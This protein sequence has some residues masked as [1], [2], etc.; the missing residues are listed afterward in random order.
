[1]RIVWAIAAKDVGEGIRNKTILGNIVAM[2]FLVLF[3]RFAPVLEGDDLPRL[4]VYDQGHSRL[5]IEMENSDQFKF[6]ELSSLDRVEL[7]VGEASEVRLGLVLP[8]GFDQALADGQPPVL[9]GYVAHWASRSEAAEIQAFF[10]GQ[11]AELSGQAVRINM[12]NVVYHQV[13][14]GGFSF[15]T[16]LGGVVALVLM[17]T[18]VTH[19][20]LEEK[21]AKTI[22]AL[23]VSPASAGQIVMG[24]AVAGLVYCLTASSM[25]FVFNAVVVVNWGLLVLATIC[26]ALFTVALGLLMGSLF[27]TRQQMTMWGFVLI[28]VLLLPVFMV[29]MGDIL[30]DVVAVNLRWFPTVALSRVMQMSFSD[31]APLGQVVTNLATVL[32]GAVL[33]LMGVDIGTFYRGLL[34]DDAG[35]DE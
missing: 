3:Y 4:I 31:S 23:M 14:W 10:E 25:V 19:L 1:L 16:A 13:G 5:V 28:S 15:L 2:V 27:E 24:K 29:I 35:L 26:G 21:Q 18:T 8:D 33:I 17:G 22:D 7:F 11:L 6:Y 9:D 34:P 30:P 32:V 20:M 12:E